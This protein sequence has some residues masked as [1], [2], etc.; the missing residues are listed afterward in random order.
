MQ[1]SKEVNIFYTPYSNPSY[2]HHEPTKSPQKTLQVTE[3]YAGLVCG[4]A[5]QGFGGGRSNQAKPS[6]ASWEVLPF[7]GN[8]FLLGLYWD[9]G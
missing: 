8:E 3:P 2:P 7:P 6:A 5:F 9:N 4:D 1:V